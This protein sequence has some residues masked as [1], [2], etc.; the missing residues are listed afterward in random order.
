MYLVKQQFDL[1][2]HV[3]VAAA[4]LVIVVAVV[5]L[6]NRKCEIFCFMSIAVSALALA[7]LSFYSKND[8]KN[9]VLA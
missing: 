3:V 6:A 4:A 1:V 2:V 7:I 9:F 5:L 8:L